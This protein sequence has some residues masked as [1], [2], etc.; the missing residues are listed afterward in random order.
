MSEYYSITCFTVNGVRFKYQ[1][2]EWKKSSSINLRQKKLYVP[3]S[4]FNHF[5]EEIHKIKTI[6]LYGILSTNIVMQFFVGSHRIFPPTSHILSSPLHSPLDSTP[7]FFLLV[8]L[9]PSLLFVSPL[10]SPL[11]TSPIVGPPMLP[12][13]VYP[14]LAT[15]LL[16]S[17]LV[18]PTICWSL[19]P[20]C[21]HWLPC[22]VFRWSLPST[23][24]CLLFTCKVSW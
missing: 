20:W 5:S 8:L 17:L 6:A 7:L 1:T 2:D 10:V 16:V 18:S 15:P 13:L 14:Y 3:R 9:M 24:S 11:T 4:E 12:P 19:S 21:R 23:L 22:Q